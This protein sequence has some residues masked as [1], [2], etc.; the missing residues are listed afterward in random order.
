MSSLLPQP[1]RF[2]GRE[3]SKPLIMSDHLVEMSVHQVSQCPLVNS[4]VPVFVDCIPHW[5][6]G[7]TDLD[8]LLLSNMASTAQSLTCCS[9]QVL[10]ENRCVGLGSEGTLSLLQETFC[11]CLGTNERKGECG[12]TIWT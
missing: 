4:S 9:P 10:L 8:H 3:G 12:Y 7:F 5:L 1:V 6:H 11:R 2:V